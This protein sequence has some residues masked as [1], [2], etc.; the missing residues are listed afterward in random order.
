MRKPTPS[1]TVTLT[2]RATLEYTI[3]LLQNYL[4]MLSHS[5]S[6]WQTSDVWQVLLDAAAQGSTIEA[7]CANWDDGPDANTIRQIL[8]LCL[9]NDR[10]DAIETAVNQALAA[11]LPA[12]LRRA[13]L[14]IAFDLHDEPYYGHAASES[15]F[16]ARGA[17]RDGTTHFYRCATAYVLSRGVRITLAIHF[18]RQASRLPVIVEC[19]RLELADM[20]IKIR[21]LFMD[22][23][24]C[25][26]EILSYLADESLPAILAAPIRGTT[27]GTR[28]LCHGRRSYRTSH[29]FRGRA[30]R[31]VTVPICVVRTY[32]RR[33]QGGRKAVWLLYVTLHCRP[34][35]VTV[36]REYRRRFGIEAS[37]RMLEQ[38]RIRTTS[39]C[40]AWRFLFMGLAVLLLLA[41]NLLQWQYTV[42]TTKGRKQLREGAFRLK[43]FLY[44]L[45]HAVDACYRP[46]TAIQAST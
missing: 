8:R 38:V 46:L 40:S 9:A 28:T 17:A 37:Y 39:T 30:Q 6:Q 36:R 29:T 33:R 27:Y 34:D 21:R 18:V 16:I 15:E 43:R 20:H 41:W 14:E 10:I 4:T 32:K 35:L 19:L 44:F 7:S 11:C 2:S 42:I 25:T 31:A 12:R 1:R 45:C 3:S 24:F 26:V 5:G 22:K 23:A 13:R